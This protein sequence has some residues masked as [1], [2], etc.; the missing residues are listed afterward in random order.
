MDG[1]D[2]GFKQPP[3]PDGASD[4]DY[5]D[6]GTPRLTLSEYPRVEIPHKLPHPFREWVGRSTASS[7]IGTL[8]LG[9]PA[10][11]G[12]FSDQRTSRRTWRVNDLWCVGYLEI[13]EGAVSPADF[14]LE[15]FALTFIHIG[16][17]QW[18]LQ[19]SAAQI[20]SSQ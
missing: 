2:I 8:G 7:R 13:A 17:R 3:F 16:K 5:A 19:G 14:T 15:I 18:G 12:H 1:A 20:W 10:L 9:L 11:D 6:A 4:P